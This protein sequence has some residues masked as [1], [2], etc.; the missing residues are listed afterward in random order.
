MNK[1]VI[2]NV[3]EEELNILEREGFEFIAETPYLGCSTYV[4]LLE[5]DKQY[6]NMVLNA[7]RRRPCGC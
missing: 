5:C 4:I 6:F 1:Y 2:Y 3:T 7:I